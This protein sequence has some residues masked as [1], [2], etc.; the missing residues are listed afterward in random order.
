MDQYASAL[1]REGHAVVLDC[2][3]LSSTLVPIDPTGAAIMIVDSNKKRTLAGSEYNTRCRECESALCRLGEAA[4]EMFPSLRH[5]PARVLELHGSQLDEKEFRRVRHNL[6]ENARV[7]AFA[8][9]MAARDFAAAGR[10]INESH[11]SLRDD[12][13]TS[14]EELDFIAARVQ[15]HAD[16]YGCR[17]TGGGFGGCAVALVK[18][19]TAP[20]IFVSFA[21]DYAQRFGYAPTLI[22]CGTADGAW[23]RPYAANA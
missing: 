11:A 5:I 20:A 19:G 23:S 2:H 7:H 6:S 18:P 21:A 3:D 1:G 22:E 16:A 17:I 9:A 13:Q 10:L 12:Y 8:K 14:C 15:A 4:G